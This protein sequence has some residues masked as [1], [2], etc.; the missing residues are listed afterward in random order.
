MENILGDLKNKDVAKIDDPDEKDIYKSIKELIEQIKWNSNENNH[1]IKENDPDEEHIMISYNT[2]SRELCLKIK[3]KLESFG[4]KIWIDVNDIHGSSLDAMAK[5]VEKSLCVL[6]CVTEK[7][8]QS[9]NC[10]AEAQYAFKMNKKII[11]LIMQAGFDNVKGWLGIIMGD[12]I[13]INFTKYDYD[14]CI[15]RLKHVLNS[16]A[17]K[18]SNLNAPSI[19]SAPLLLSAPKAISM[20]SNTNQSKK[21][22]IGKWSELEVKEWFLKNKLNI[23]IFDYLKPCNGLALK[24]MHKMENNVSEFFYQSLNKIENLKFN[25]IVQFSSCLNILFSEEI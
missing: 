25:E 12:K 14:E 4:F 6:M 17:S 9:I 11:P 24:Q 16:I 18:S 21:A 1:P 13:F 22:S 23:S 15:R 2:G 7:Y 20:T 3:E 8:R 5:A 10:Q 19:T